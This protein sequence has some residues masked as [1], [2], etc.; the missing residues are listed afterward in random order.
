M[1]LA[2]FRIGTDYVSG[3]RWQSNVGGIRATT[4]GAI[5]RRTKTVRIVA[6]LSADAMHALAARS[7]LAQIKGSVRVPEGTRAEIVPEPVSMSPDGQRRDFAVQFVP[8]SSE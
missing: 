4:H 2:N 6:S 1:E 7:L 5:R 8:V 3:D